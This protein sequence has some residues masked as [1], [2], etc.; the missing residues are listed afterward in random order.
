MHHCVDGEDRVDAAD[1]IGGGEIIEHL[2]WYASFD[3]ME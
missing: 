1:E 3:E 2:G